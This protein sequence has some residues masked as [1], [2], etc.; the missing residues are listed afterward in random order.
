MAPGTYALGLHTTQ[1]ELG[2][3]LTNFS[4][5]CRYQVWTLGRGLSTHLHSHLA[6]FI[7]PQQWSA[8]SFLAVATGPGSF[9]GTRI[10]VVTARTLAQQLNLPLFPISTT[11][12]LAW[13]HRVAAK[14]LETNLPLRIAVEMPA[15]RGEVFGAIYE[16]DQI[17]A[18]LS[19]VLADGRFA[20]EVWQ[21]HLENF[22]PTKH[23]QVDADPHT[24]I[25][26]QALLDLAFLR[27]QQGE[28][29]PWSATLPFY[30]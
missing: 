4:N 2:L 9:T 27:W 25:A 10:G 12:A 20:L 15:Q 1:S 13:A 14:T 26:C 24:K 23:L 29:P 30:G 3:R 6:E 8:L 28:R 16:I 18:S 22:Q 11:A 19:P 17:E 7:L 21:Q 5:D